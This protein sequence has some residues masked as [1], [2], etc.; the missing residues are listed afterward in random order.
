MGEGWLLPAEMVELITE[1]VTN[2]VCTQPFGCLPNH[3]AGKGMIRKIRELY[4]QANIVAVDYDPARQNKPREPHQ[5]DAILR[6]ITLIRPKNA[7][8]A[9]FSFCAPLRRGGFAALRMSR[10]PPPHSMK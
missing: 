9:A 6:R 7:A 8:D 1:G 10:R 2:I 3:I 5:A 4:P